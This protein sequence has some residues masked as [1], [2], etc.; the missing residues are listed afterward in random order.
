[1]NRTASIP[2]WTN[3]MNRMMN[4]PLVCGLVGMALASTALVAGDF[5][6]DT[7]VNNAIVSYPGTDPYPPVIDATN[8]INN[9]SF[10]INFTSISGLGQPFYETWNTANYTNNGLLMANSGFQFDNQSSVSGL[11]TPSAN[12][13]NPGTISCGSV[14]D[15][16]DPLLGELDL[17]GYAQ[18]LVSATNILCPGTVDVGGYGLI[19]FTGQNVDLSRSTLNI[20]PL[21]ADVSGAGVFSLNTNLWDPSAY[22]GANF[23]LTPPIAAA[24]PFFF[25]GNLLIDQM[26]LTNSTAYVHVANN[27][28]GPSN[29]I[30]RAVFIEDNSGPNV[31][32]SVYFDTAGLDFGNGNVTIQWAGSYLDAASGNT[33]TNYLYL[34]DNYVLGASTNVLPV[35]GIPI[36]FQFSEATSPQ[37]VTLAPTP[38]GLPLNLFPVG[39]ITN[40]YDFANVQLLSSISTN[41]IANYSVTN[42]PS[43][44]QMSATSNLDLSF[45]QLTGLN[46]MSIQSTNMFIG[47]AG[48]FIQTPY[49]DLNLGVTNGLL[50]ITNVMEAVH[51]DLERHGAGVEHALA[52][53]HFDPRH[54]Q[55]FPRADRRQRVESDD[56]GASA[57][58]DSAFPNGTN[59]I[60]DQRHVQR[61]AHFYCRCAKPDADH[62]PARLRRHLGGR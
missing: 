33:Y 35:V 62:K 55:R 23:A 18:C 10:T 52:G 2:P 44:I 24:P 50:T 41:A 27:R 53:Y 8:F 9:N 7:Y 20:E 59:S 13:F 34:N 47:S 12:F 42:L 38:P 15:T 26:Y 57:G 39:G 21:G 3:F 28:P 60:V 31:S 58:F 5:S 11:R 4:W 29:N 54:Y 16:S 37:I 25:Y 19:K 36:N 46:Y 43:R 17:L 30:I 1:M 40:L 32:V 48:A 49:A 61:H 22:L 45:A 6:G 14:S 56:P 51:S